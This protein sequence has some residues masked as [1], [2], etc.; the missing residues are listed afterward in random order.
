[1][2]TLPAGGHVARFIDQLFPGADTGNFK[3]TLFVSADGSEE[4]VTAT[5]IQIGSRAGEFTTMPVVAVDP[6]PMTTELYFAQFANGA[7]WTTSL[8]LTNPTGSAST[9]AL[10][11]YDDEGNP[12]SM[13]VNGQ[14]SASVNSAMQAQGGVFIPT[15]GDGA[16]VSGSARVTSDNGIGGVLRFASP[17]LGMAGVGASEAVDG[18]IAPVSR[19]AEGNFSTGVAVA[20]IGSPVT[21]RVTLRNEK[22]EAVAGGQVTLELRANGHFARFVEQL[23]PE[24]DTKDFH[25]TITVSAEGGKIAGT[26]IQI[27]GRAGQFTTL[28]VTELR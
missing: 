11:F 17:A 21:L 19:N 3:G 15:D 23:F 14:S 24:A 18:F 27:G 20:S 22:G 9:G 7:D 1:M 26:A 16:L 10:T 8:F 6:L 25:G 2:Q 13:S 28:P 5:V 12:L 4:S